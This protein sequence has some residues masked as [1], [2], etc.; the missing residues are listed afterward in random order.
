MSPASPAFPSPLYSSGPFPSSPDGSG[1]P[2]TSFAAKQGHD[3]GAVVIDSPFLSSSPSDKYQVNL[4]V[5]RQ[6]TISPHAIYAKRQ[7]ESCYS[8][9]PPPSSAPSSYG[10]YNSLPISVSM[11]PSHSFSNPSSPI[12][13]GSFPSS[14]P[15]FGNRI[16]FISLWAEGMQP[17]TVPA[18]ASPATVLL[19]PTLLRMKLRLPSI[20]DV[21]SPQ[22]LHGFHGTVTLA[23]PWASA[24]ECTTKVYAN[25]VCISQESG[26]LQQV[27]NSATTTEGLMVQAFLPES[28]LS[29]S[30]WLDASAC[31][32]HLFHY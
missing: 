9:M 14:P 21:R 25:N 16:C 8:E 30:R 1:I 31:Y 19:P 20:D 23:A 2:L 26:S 22:T 17:L 4:P 7:Y 18:V 24:A 12:A 6:G 5:P 28:P 29:R 3:E 32:F 15:L 13:L 10:R 27:S 11:T